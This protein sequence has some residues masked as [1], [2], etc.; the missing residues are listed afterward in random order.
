[1]SAPVSSQG[2]SYRLAAF[3][4]DGTLIGASGELSPATIATLRGLDAAGVAIV[5][6]TTRPYEIATPMFASLGLEVAVI[7]STGADVRLVDGAIVE[8]RTLPE[9]HA[10][11]V[12]RLCDESDWG[13]IVGS[14]DGAFRRGRPAPTNGAATTSVGSLAELPL[15]RVFMIAPFVTPADTSYAALDEI[16][17]A[18]RLR[19]ERAV[20][21]AG[22]ELVAITAEGVGK[23]A[24][25]RRLCEALAIPASQA[26]AF[27]DAEVDVPMFEAAGRGVAMGNAPAAVRGAA[28]EVTGS[29]D[30]DGVAASV[31]RIWG[32]S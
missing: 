32:L 7:A 14:A 28:D 12:A 17:R 21:S 27:G 23:G 1:M 19:S 18:G 24:A 10:R 31:R 5:A 6:A 4:I 16:L 29:A 30:E 15:D 26:V 8:Q 3:D 9:A 11:E 2:M 22:Q 13:T 25:L 20:T